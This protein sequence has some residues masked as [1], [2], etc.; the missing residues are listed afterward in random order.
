MAL[1]LKAQPEFVT[2]FTASCLGSK[3][4]Y[5]NKIYQ[6]SKLQMQVLGL[7][8]KRVKLAKLEGYQRPVCLTSRVTSETAA[9]TKKK[10]G[11]QHP[12]R[13]LNCSSVAEQI[14]R[15]QKAAKKSQVPIGCQG[16]EKQQPL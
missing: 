12:A 9:N 4:S 13:Q 10:N 5:I 8:C 15:V 2:P 3:F 16:I 14:P 1:T 6:A 7:I 11:S